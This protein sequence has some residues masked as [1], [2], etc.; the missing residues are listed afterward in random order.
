M[1]W[2][3]SVAAT[4][5]IAG[6]VHAGCHVNQ[7]VAAPLVTYQPII[8]QPVFQPVVA[9][10]PVIAAPLIQQQAYYPQQA[11]IQRQAIQK[12]FAPQR[13]FIKTTQSERRGLFGGRRS[14]QTQRIINR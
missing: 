10:Y 2:I 14:V 11:I 1:K 4:M 5:L 6:A 12:Q 7:V 3:L 13:Q 8:A 9:Q